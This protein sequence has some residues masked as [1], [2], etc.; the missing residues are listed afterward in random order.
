MV[1]ACTLHNA[2]LALRLLELPLQV[3][4]R[5]GAVRRHHQLGH[6]LAVRCHKSGRVEFNEAHQSPSKE[7]KHEQ[8]IDD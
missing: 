7:Q 6:T 1:H 3:D 5:A 4:A 2:H 8:K